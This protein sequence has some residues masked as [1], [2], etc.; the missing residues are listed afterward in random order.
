[1][2]S[3][4]FS[5]ISIAAMACASDYK[6]LKP[7]TTPVDCVEALKP[8]Q[9]ATSWYDASI[10][11]EGHQFGGLLV[12]K[13]MSEQS[14]R[15]VFTTETGAT[16]FDFEYNGDRFIVHRIVSKLDRRMIVRVLEKDFALLLGVPFL[17]GNLSVF[18]TENEQYFGVS[19]NGER[20]FI[21]TD[22]SCNYRR[23]EQGS[24]KKRLFSIIT[25]G[26]RK[27]PDL[28]TIT[29]YTFDM[30]IELKRIEKDATQ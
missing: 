12:I 4:L 21:V 22:K 29:H 17:Q 30:A 20:S 1:M 16:I 28:I 11:L 24:E 2:R 8:V 18:E 19:S 25:K 10:N 15:V 5:L 14:Y 23:L 13:P 27:S 9:I 6:M 3:F 7:V 26:E